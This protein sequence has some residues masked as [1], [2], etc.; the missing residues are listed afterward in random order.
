MIPR[1]PILVGYRGSIAHGMYVPNSD[2][3]S[4]DD[5]DI[6]SVCIPP[7]EYYFGFDRCGFGDRGVREAVNGEWDSVAYE[8]KKFIGLMTKS[9][10]NV[11]SMLWLEP[12]YYV[13]VSEI[14]RA[15]I[16]NRKLFVSKK[17]YHSFTGY[18]HNQLHRMEHQAFE[19]YMGEK[20]KSLVLKHG[21]DTKNAAHCIRL[22]RMGIEFLNEGVLYVDRSRMDGPQLLEIKRGEWPLEKVKTEAERLF[23]R[24][25]DVYD[26]STLPVEPDVMEINKLTVGWLQLHFYIE[27]YHK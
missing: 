1:T 4:I 19:G 6:M 22:L 7:V 8:F 25:E 21:Y 2:P 18:A 17:I 20:R 26:H 10:P 13:Y 27:D 9:N 16:D 11:L 14:G 23:R 5:K 24:A 12:Q 3:N 15:L